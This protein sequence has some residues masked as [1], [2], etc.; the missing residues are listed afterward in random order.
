MRQIAPNLWV[1]ERPQTFYG[2]ELGTRMTV[3]RLRSGDLWVHSPVAL[4]SSI[5]A[6][7]DSIGAIR[8]IIAPNRFHHLYAGQWRAAYPD[9]R[10][11]AAPGLDTKRKD[12]KFDSV[13]NDDGPPEWRD[14]IDQ[15]VFRA[16]A[17]LNEVVFCDRASATLI[18]TDLM[19]N[20]TRSESVVARALLRLD[21]AFAEPAVPRSFRALIRWR[22]YAAR[23]ALERIMSW[24]FD[25]LIVAHGD[26]VETGAKQAVENAWRFLRFKSPA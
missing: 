1:S 8:F 12:L 10:M 11:F 17:P 4:D 23:Q 2:L 14:Q 9:A 19:F 5:R 7:V 24:N 16:F 13:L 18:F 22:R 20:I 6:E 21:G 3:I 26:I 15:L 25:R